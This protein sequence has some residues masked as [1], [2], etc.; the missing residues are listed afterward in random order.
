VFL[1]GLA[2]FQSALALGAPFGRFT[3][4]GS[5][6]VLDPPM[7]L[8]S[9]GAAAGLCLA[10]SVMLVRS[11]DLG[12]RASQR[13]FRVLNV[14]IAALLALNTLANLASREIGER[15]G[16]G[17]AAALGCILCLGALAE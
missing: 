6:P 2:A 17:A 3:W 12:T 1:A 11:G 14:L 7:R 5:T 4:G 15:I 8:A 13:P 9:L 16:M 10:S